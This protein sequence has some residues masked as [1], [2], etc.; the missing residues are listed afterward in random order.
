MKTA[1]VILNWNGKN[2]LEKFLQNVIF[3]SSDATVIVVD[4]NSSDNSVSFLQ[5]KFPEIQIIQNEGNY[6][7]A[8]GYNLA[9][10]QIDA[11]YF[12]LLNSDIEVTKDW[13]SPIVSLM[14][15][16]KTISAC[17][18]KILDYNNKSKFEYAGASGGYIDKFG[19]PFCRGRI[20]D[21]LEEDK[22]QYNDAIEVF[23]ATGACLFVRS[24]QFLEIGGLDEDF[25]AHQEEIDLCWRLKNKGYKIM[26]EPKSEVYHVGGGTLNVGSPFKTHLNFRN[27]L[28]MLFKNLP[29]S[30]LFTIIPVRLVLD[31]I[32][33]ITFL[34]KEKGMRHLFAIS[35]AH[36]AF[37]F[38]IPKL[39]SKRRKISQKCSLTGKNNYSILVKNKIIGIK[40]FSDL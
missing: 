16:D 12:V 8:K 18:P 21:E 32:A 30:S 13:I 35:K 14:D 3:N 11:E 25:F 39:I 38:E 5:E 20:F 22:G 4:N 17:Q 36:F 10:K 40:K 33:A 2:W 28:Y 37:Y 23:W 7:Y 9:L 26:V 24:S 19:Y 6:G 29:L 31:G 27:N 1:V 34:K 15:S